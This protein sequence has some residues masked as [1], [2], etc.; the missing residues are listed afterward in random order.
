MAVDLHC[1]ECLK[2]WETHG[3][4]AAE[5]RDVGHGPGSEIIRARLQAAAQ[6]IR[7]HEMQFHSVQS[8]RR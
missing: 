6:A 5:L 1:A 8:A 7:E 2:L 4:A 3:A